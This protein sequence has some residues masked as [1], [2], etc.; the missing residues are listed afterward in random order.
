MDVIHES[1]LIHMSEAVGK[2]VFTRQLTALKEIIKQDL[3]TV[4]RP[5]IQETKQKNNYTYSLIIW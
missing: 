5:F 4:K 3:D 1:S 2:Q